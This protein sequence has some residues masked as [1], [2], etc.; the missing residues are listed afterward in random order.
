MDARTR[1]PPIGLVAQKKAIVPSE[2]DPWARALFRLRLEHQDAADFVIIDEVG[3]NLDMTPRYGRAPRGQRAHASVPRNTPSNTSVIASC[4][5]RGMGPSMMVVGGVDTPAF[6][7]YLTQVLGPSLR[8][9]QIVVLDNLSVHTGQQ[10]ATILAQYGCTRWHLPTYSPDYS[11]IE[12][13]FAKAKQQIRRAAARTRDALEQ[14]VADAWA[15]I[16]PTD[17]GGFFAH[18]GYRLITDLN[19]LQCP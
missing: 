4:S 3:L 1:H 19:Q 8:P 11:P 7:T 17:M 14:A 16:T 9:G 15:A 18:C 2:R 10:I 6:E 13:A 12:L 5:L